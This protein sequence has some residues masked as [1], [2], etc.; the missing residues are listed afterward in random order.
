M[1]PSFAPKVRNGQALKVSL[2]VS[3]LQCMKNEVIAGFRD[4]LL[5]ICN[6]MGLPAHGRQ[7]KLAQIASNSDKRLT[8]NAAGKWL[9]G[10][11]MP[12]LDKAV[13]IANWAKVNINWLLQ[14]VGPKHGDHVDSTLL[15]VLE[16]VT[17]LPSGDKAQVLDFVRYKFHTTKGW[18]AA[19]KLAVYDNKLDQLSAQTGPKGYSQ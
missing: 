9:H 16:G 6:D 4:R 8:P 7:T 2:P 12:E 11:G 18:F 10:E 15:A 1:S 19:E 5:E 13:R 17:E 3:N 14:G